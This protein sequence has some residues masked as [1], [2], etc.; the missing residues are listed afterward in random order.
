MSKWGVYVKGV[1]EKSMVK[2][3][4]GVHG[5]GVNRESMVKE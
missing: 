2:S 4:G 1:K 3:K 5:K